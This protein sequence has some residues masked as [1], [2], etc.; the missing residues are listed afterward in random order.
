VSHAHGV[1]VSD[2]D[3]I[4]LARVLFREYLEGTIEETGLP[5]PDESPTVLEWMRAEVDALPGPYVPPDGAL[6]RPGG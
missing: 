3:D 6:R 1:V 2:C 5:N 4:P